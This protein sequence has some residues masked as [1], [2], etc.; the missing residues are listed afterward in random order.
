MSVRGQRSVYTDGG[1]NNPLII[2]D[3]M[4]FYGELSEINLNDIAQIDI[5]KDASSAAV[6]GAKAANGVVIVTT[7]KGKSEKPVVN[8]SANTG[9]TTMADSRNVY[10]ADGYLKYRTDFYTTDTYGVNPSSGKYEAYQTGNRPAGYYDRPTD[11]NLSKYG[12][13]MDTWRNQ[14]TQDPGMSNDE[15]W[16][17]RIGLNASEVTLANFLAGKTF[18]WYDHSFHTGMNQD[19]NISVGGMTEKINY[20][21]SMGYLSNEGVVRGNEYSAIRSNTK[22]DA[23]VTDWFSMGVNINFQNRTD[24]DIATDWYNQITSNSPFATP[25]DDKGKLVAHPQGENAYWKGYNF[26]YN[27]QFLDLEKGFTV[28]NSIL[29]AK[30]TLPFGITYSLNASPRLQYFHDRYYR[31]S[32]HPDWQ[33]ETE[34]RVIREQSKRFDWSL[35]NTVAWDYTF[36]QKHHTILTLVQEAEERESWAD[37]IIARNILPSEALGLHA[38]ANAD[39]NLSEFKATDVRETATGYLARLFYSY[40]NKYMGTFSFRRDG[41]SAFGTTNPYANFLSGALAWTFTNEDFWKW[42]DALDSGKLRVSFGQNGNRSLADSYIALANLALGQ[43]SQGYINAA[44]NTLMDMKYLFVN[45][46]PNTNLQWEKTTSWNAGLDLSFLRGRIN[47]SL[48]YYIMPTTDMI[49]NQ[50]LPVLPVLPV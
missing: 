31:S 44:S 30:L 36:A 4:M 49:M 26:D 5:L 50:S 46:L 28:L 9:W 16:A 41:Y 40:D 14:T 2:L 6:Y 43:Y 48:E 8:F 3:G 19:Y 23:K 47:T 33:A 39:K 32:E 45:R 27:R 34:D 18:D 37:R 35:N 24:G 1:H 38:N 29:T 15:V 12:L 25:Y 20:Y 22:L 42:S 11:A 17:R 13:T 21:F 7:K 10:G